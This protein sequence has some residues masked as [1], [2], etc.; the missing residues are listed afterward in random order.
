[1]PELEALLPASVAGIDLERLSITGPDFYKTGTDVNRS[2]LDELLKNLGKTVADLSVAD[3]GDPTGR[4]VFE[5]GIFRV[6]GATPAQ[7]LSEW[8][9]FDQAAKPGRI[10]V[11][12]RDGRRTRPSPRSSIR[13]SPSAGR[14]THSPSA[15]RSTWSRRTIPSSSRPRSPPCPSPDRRARSGGVG[16]TRSALPGV[17]STTMPATRRLLTGDRPDGTPIQPIQSCP[18]SPRSPWWAPCSSPPAAAPPPR[19]R[20]TAPA[21]SAAPRPSGGFCSSA[22]L[23]ASIPTKVNDDRPP[24]DRGATP[25]WR[26]ASLPDRSTT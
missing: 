9:A 8:V 12:S 17:P 22:S 7:L 3:A 20:P 6:A 23:T 5:L 25:W 26:T 16:T 2:Q 15:T 13:A 19:A 14:P 1:M 11:T 10:K 18:T 4:A 21:P 24:D